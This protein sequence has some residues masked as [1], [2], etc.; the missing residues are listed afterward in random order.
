MSWVICHHNTML[1]QPGTKSGMI[2]V[3]MAIFYPPYDADE[4]RDIEKAGDHAESRVLNALFDLAD[5]WRVFY[6]LNWREIE[7]SGERSGE[8]DLIIFHPQLG[9]LV[10]EV[11]GGGIKIENS[12]WFYESLFDRTKH[13]M[14]ISPL[15]QARRNRYYLNDRLKG[16]QTGR[17]ILPNTAL[18]YTAWFPDITWNADLPPDIPHGGFILDSRHLQNPAKHI[19]SILTQSAPNRGAWS[20]RQVQALIKLLAPEVDLLP[21]LGAVLGTIRDRLHRM[22]EGQITALRSLRKQKR[23][24]VEG[25]AGSGKTLLAVR[26]AQDHIIEGKRVLFT[27]FNKNLAERVTLEFEGNSAID[28]CNFHEYTKRLC[29]KCSF[30]FDVPSEEDKRQEFFSEKCPE[31]LLDASQNVNPKYDTIIVDEAY[32]FRESWWI[33]LAALGT[34]DASLYVFYDPNQN[35]FNEAGWQPPFPGDPVVLD[36]NVRNTRPVGEFAMELGQIKDQVR[37]AV[38]DGP[39]PVA[40]TYVNTSEVAGILKGL[41]DD[42]VRHK[43]IPPEDIVVLSPYKYSS[44]RLG[45]KGLIDAD[46]SL[47]TANIASRKDR[48]WVG[49]IQAFKGLEADV[50]ILCGIDGHLPACGSA[51]LYVGATRARSMLYIINQRDFA[52]QAIRP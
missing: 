3:A 25:C 41:I 48:V 2:V 51:N 42:L 26:L 14:R 27:C 12:R 9:I 47:F 11:K 50:V 35:L 37:F 34:P 44:D 31:L 1:W 45:I 10:V 40:R 5:D 15:E 18:T 32:D 29:E 36:T 38:T 22:T 43:K 17:E 16:T 49:T 21:P 30:L 20:A 7:R 52:L 28:V 46:P 8:I 13:E 33:A 23:L 39:K 24:L 4:K 6:D 19:R